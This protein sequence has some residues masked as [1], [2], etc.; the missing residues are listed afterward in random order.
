VSPGLTATTATE[1]GNGPGTDRGSAPAVDLR[2]HSSGDARD[3]DV[4]G[5]DAAA[6]TRE[7]GLA[8]VM[9][10]ADGTVESV[11]RPAEILLGCRAVD[12]IGNAVTML[13]QDECRGELA[14]TFERVLTGENAARYET[15]WRP[16]GGVVVLAFDLLALRLRSGKALG[17]AAVV[18]DVTERRRPENVARARLVQ[19]LLEHE[20]LQLVADRE[21]IGRDLQDLVI[22]RLFAIGLALQGSVDL[23]ELPEVAR[24]I[25]AAVE[26]LDGAI[27]D[28]RTIIFA[29]EHHRA[30]SS[31][32]LRAH[33]LTE[34]SEATGGFGHGP[35][36][37]PNGPVEPTVP[38]QIGGR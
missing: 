21:R 6:N 12:V 4:A 23:I 18:R 9:V 36:L 35:T 24:R 37:R 31:H 14:I 10:A 29:L 27:V 22:Q 32:S 33:I 15:E 34:I 8:L 13:E 25:S 28:I 2:P 38:D 26:D 3:G 1:D 19:T 5:T 17:V 7:T 16:E 30:S 20:Q 11:N